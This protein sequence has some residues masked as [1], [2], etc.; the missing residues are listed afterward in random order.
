MHTR[1]SR[2]SSLAL[3]TQALWLALA[4]ALMAWLLPALAQAQSNSPQAIEAVR[5][6][7]AA[8]AGQPR[9]APA[10]ALP[11]PA[12]HERPF[13]S[14]ANPQANPHASLKSCMD[15][16]GMNMAARDRC[17]RQHCDGRWG[18]G[19]CPA[20]SGNVLVPTVPNR[21]TPLGRCLT[22][23]GG[24]PF[25][26]DACGWQHCKGKSDASAECAALYP[27]TRPQSMY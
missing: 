10:D 9:A 23:A 21:A 12:P 20:S 8:Q 6:H 5:Q 17:M 11:Q 16:A 22:E 18:Q 25:R 13:R 27:R 24:N 4:L 1:T 2:L 19:D 14:S 7:R 3:N 26:R 15:H